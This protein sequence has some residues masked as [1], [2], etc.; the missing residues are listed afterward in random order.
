[1]G[2]AAGQHAA[3][4][5]FRAGCSKFGWFQIWVVPSLARGAAHVILVLLEHVERGHHVVERPAVAKPLALKKPVSQKQSGRP[6]LSLRAVIRGR[7]PQ[8]GYGVGRS[9]LRLSIRVGVEVG[10]AG[11][12]CYQG[13]RVRV[14][15]VRVAVSRCYQGGTGSAGGHRVTCLALGS[16]VG[17]LL[18]AVEDV[19]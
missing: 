8:S 14:L 12:G 15:G 6:F 16:P 11:S 3:P 17:Q 18:G 1:M 7:G 2:S 19:R 10:V 5:A 9:G 4:A 13:V